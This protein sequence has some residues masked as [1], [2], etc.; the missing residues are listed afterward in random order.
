MSVKLSSRDRLELNVCATAMEL[1]LAAVNSMT[2]EIDKSRK[3]KRGGDAPYRIVNHT[4]HDVRVWTEGRTETARDLTDGTTADWAF[5]DWRT[6]RENVSSVGRH[7]RLSV[8]VQGKPWEAVQGIPVDRE[9]Q[10]SIVLRPKLEPLGTRLLCE[11]TV[12]NNVKIV[13]LRSSFKIENKTLYPIEISLGIDSQP[14]MVKK[15]RKLRLSL[16]LVFLLILCP[17]AEPRLLTATNVRDPQYQ[18]T[19]RW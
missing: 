15:L 10:R 7:N 12:D 5:D 19:A 13:T 17:S 18:D 16:T 1:A 4:G 9:G 8:Q 2:K 6:V 3:H 11:I 14:Y